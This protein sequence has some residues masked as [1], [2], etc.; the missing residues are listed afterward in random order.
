MVESGGRTVAIN[1]DFRRPTLSARLG[2]VD[3]EPAGF[4]L[5]EIESAP[6]ELV[7][8]P[9]RDPGLAVLDLSGIRGSTPGDLARVTAKILP[10]VAQ[11]ADSVVVDTSPV[12]ATA[13]VLEFVPQADN[14]VM[15]VRLDH[16]T[17]STAR[18]SIETIRTLSKG[19]LL[20]VLVGADSG[21]DAYYYYYSS[22]P[23]RGDAE[24]SWFGRR[25]GRADADRAVAPE[26][27][28]VRS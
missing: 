7:L 12:G 27:T 2:V 26:E 8:A 1:T 3:A 9:A 18:R 24:S 20:L 22:A 5:H 25:K 23:N 6:L 14:I 19:N 13:E 10:R 17:A 4:D 11:I 28:T 15:V 21:G 16:T